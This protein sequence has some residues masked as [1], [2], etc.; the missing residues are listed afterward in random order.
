MCPMLLVGPASRRLV[1]FESPKFG[2]D[3]GEER[4]ARMAMC[5]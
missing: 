5:E 1:G 3:D 4:M 2:A